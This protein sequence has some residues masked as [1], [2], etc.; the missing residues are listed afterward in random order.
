MELENLQD[1]AIA[2]QE[3]IDN[4]KIYSSKAIW[5]F[6]V[7]F[8][9]IFGGVL[10]MQNLKDIGKNKEA[11]LVL[12][13]CILYA[14]ATVIVVNIP[15]HPNSSITYLINMAGGAILVNL[16]FKKHFPEDSQYEKK[17]IWKPLLISII[18]T[19]PFVLALIYC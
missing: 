2:T 18:I 11:N 12:L 16:V 8:S 3:I 7:F 13:S 6:S 17:K 5:G 10:L 19:V 1:D 4:P 14:I 15:E 9:T